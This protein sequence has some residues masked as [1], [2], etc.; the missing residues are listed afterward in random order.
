MNYTPL[1]QPLQPTQHPYLR[2]V[3]AF[4]WKAG[5]GSHLR[6]DWD[7]CV[8]PSSPI[9]AYTGPIVFI[10][11]DTWWSFCMPRKRNIANNSHSLFIFLP[12]QD[13]SFYSLCGFGLYCPFL[14]I[15][16]NASQLYKKAWR[17]VFWTK[18]LP[19][20]SSPLQVPH[21]WQHLLLLASHSLCS[22]AIW[23]LILFLWHC[24]KE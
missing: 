17:F 18:K 12:D 6:A 7:Y 16:I 10:W 5:E 2:R 23:D 4:L 8:I 20:L 1:C 21:F 15:S 22:V 9:L 19:W 11:M 24:H 13:I 3:S 14:G